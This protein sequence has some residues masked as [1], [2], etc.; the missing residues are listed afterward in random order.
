MQKGFINEKKFAKMLDKNKI[1]ELNANIQDLIYAIF[2]DV[3]E[4]DIVECW[5]SKYFEK[6]DIKIKINNEIKGVSIKTGKYCS[7]HQEST[8]SLYPFF[9]RIGIDERIINKLD[10]FLIGEVDGKRLDAI[11]YIFHNYDEIKMIKETLNNYYI[12]VNLILRFLFQGTEKQKYGCDA[13]IYGVPNKFTWATKEEILEYL[14]NYDNN[15]EVYL[16][17]SALNLKSYDRNLRNNEMRKTKQNEIQIKWCT[18]NADLENIKKLR[19]SNKNKKISNN[20]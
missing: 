20:Y 1:K 7:M 14:V 8:D 3:G 10:N 16:K 5:T 13:I 17:F 19:V 11:T 2:I 12:K 6:A 18:I 9:R 4:D 15:H